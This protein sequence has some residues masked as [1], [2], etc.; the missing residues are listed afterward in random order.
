MHGGTSSNSYGAAFFAPRQC[1][2]S[3]TS[4]TRLPAI[5][6]QNGAPILNTGM[7]AT[8]TRKVTRAPR[9]KRAWKATVNAAC[10]TLSMAS[11][12]RVAMKAGGGG[13]H[14]AGHQRGEQ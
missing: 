2:H 8:V 10:S 3:S 4:D 11:P 5:K 1:S 13:Q 9:A 7:P 14:Q 6:A 12:A